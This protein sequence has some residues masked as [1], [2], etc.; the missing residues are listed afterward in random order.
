[1]LTERKL[2]SRRGL[3]LPYKQSGDSGDRDAYPSQRRTTRS[4]S[5][6]TRPGL[7]LESQTEEGGGGTRS[8]ALV[9]R[10]RPRLTAC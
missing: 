3:P 6:R 5:V 4:K 7:R 10:G 1:M 9:R 8:D 2:P